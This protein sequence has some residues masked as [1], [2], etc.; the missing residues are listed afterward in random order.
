MVRGGSGA[1]TGCGS[2]ESSSGACSRITWAFVPLIP[3]E[4]TP[5][6]RGP[7]VSG[8]S[9]PSV[10]SSTAPA[11]QSTWVLG[12]PTCRVLGSTPFRS[13]ST[14]LITP[15]TPE[16][17]WVCAMFDL[18]EP[19]QSGRPSCRS[20]P[21]VASSACAS[22]GSPSDV[23]VPCASTM[24]TSASASPALATACRITRC[25]EGPFGALRP[26]DAPSWFTADPRI[27]ARTG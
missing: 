21:Y 17:A 4:D 10:S 12:F 25:C 26:F 13:A 11:D 2:A 15:A 9:R 22:I 23:P 19:S 16:T 20:W 8:H 3:N 18:S 27:T 1:S 14:V 6:R 5:A 7:P 24:S